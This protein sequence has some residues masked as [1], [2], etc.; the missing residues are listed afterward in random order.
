MFLSIFYQP[1]PLLIIIYDIAQKNPRSSPAI[2]SLDLP[3]KLNI[4][5]LKKRQ[6]SGF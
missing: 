6:T 5:F 3:L 2:L 1:T 4:D